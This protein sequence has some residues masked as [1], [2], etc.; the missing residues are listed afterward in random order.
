MRWFC[1]ALWQCCGCGRNVRDA[2]PYPIMR[3]RL[4]A[5]VFGQSSPFL[6]F[7]PFSVFGCCGR[8]RQTSMSVILPSSRYL[9]YATFFSSVN[10]GNSCFGISAS[11]NLV[12]LYIGIMYFLAACVCLALHFRRYFWAIA[13]SLYI[14]YV[15][16]S[17]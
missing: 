2:V 1:L 5:A 15:Y 11:G 9:F 14:V 4:P 16:R 13:V 17:V 3:F 8:N 10:D 12:V 6:P 7:L